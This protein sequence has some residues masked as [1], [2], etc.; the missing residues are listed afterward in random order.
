M[1]LAVPTATPAFVLTGLFSTVTIDYV[2]S[3]EDCCSGMLY[4]MDAL[5]DTQQH[6]NIDGKFNTLTWTPILKKNLMVGQSTA[7]NTQV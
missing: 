4:R 3:S 5:P 7:Y 2:K 1:P 6:W